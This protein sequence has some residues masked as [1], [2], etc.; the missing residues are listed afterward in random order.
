[1]KALAISHPHVS[2]SCFCHAPGYDGKEEMGN[3]RRK[4]SRRESSGKARSPQKAFPDKTHITGSASLSHPSHYCYL[5]MLLRSEL[6]SR[7]CYCSK[8]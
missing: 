6:L 7:P 3:G 4:S 2:P 8:D 1:M 5:C